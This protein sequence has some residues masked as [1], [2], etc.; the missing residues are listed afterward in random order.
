MPPNSLML[1]PMESF[2]F[3]QP[4]VFTVT[5]LNA[6]LRE[7]LETDE[8]LQDLWVRGEISISPSPAPVT[9]TLHSKIPKLRCAA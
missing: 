8:V 1:Y 2:D 7:L 3:L 4:L 9:C 6:Y 5:A